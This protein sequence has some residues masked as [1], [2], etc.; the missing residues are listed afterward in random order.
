MDVIADKTVLQNRYEVVRQ[1][2]RG[3]MGAV[4]LATDRRFGSTVALKQT[5]V[6]GDQLRKAFEREAKLL[7]SLQHASMPHVIDY[8][9]EGEGQF[10]VMQF[11]P[12]EDLGHMLRARGGPFEVAQ[13][14]VWLD[15]LLDLLDYLHSHE[16][17]VIHR[18]IKPENL[19]VTQR[20][21]V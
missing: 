5:L 4:Y 12:G 7:N 19:K 3:G 6:S 10:L 8:F 2:G 17:P 20:G 18:D 11:I 9:F 13:V 16:P 14:L 1:L 15:E 21:K